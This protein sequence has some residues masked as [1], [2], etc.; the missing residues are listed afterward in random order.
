MAGADY[1]IEMLGIKFHYN[2]ISKGVIDIRD[3][4][5]FLG[6]IFLFM[7]VTQ[8]NVAKR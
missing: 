8:R 5:Y 6:V 7:V 2:S 1:Y 3:V 4:I